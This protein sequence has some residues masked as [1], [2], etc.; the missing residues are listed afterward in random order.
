MKTIKF[1]FDVFAATSKGAT[2]QKQRSTI[3]IQNKR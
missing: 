2:D 3:G 1:H